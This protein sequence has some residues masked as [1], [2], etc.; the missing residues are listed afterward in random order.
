MLGVAE[1]W[2]NGA[3]FDLERAAADAAFES[4]NLPILRCFALNPDC[5]AHFLN[6]ALEGES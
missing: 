1:G 3:T 5:D 2:L 4:G 6:R